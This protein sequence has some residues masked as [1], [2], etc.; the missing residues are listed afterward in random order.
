MAHRPRRRIGEHYCVHCHIQ[1][2][3][4]SDIDASM[5]LNCQWGEREFLE[6]GSYA[7]E[8]A[9]MEEFYRAEAATCSACGEQRI[10]LPRGGE[11]CIND[12][13]AEPVWLKEKLFS[14]YT[15]E[16]L[17][18]F[19]DRVRGDRAELLRE[20][21][22]QG[23]K[24]YRQEQI[25]NMAVEAAQAEHRRAREERLTYEEGTRR[26]EELGRL[27][28]RPRKSLPP[29]PPDVPHFDWLGR[30]FHGGGGNEGRRGPGRF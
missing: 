2:S 21:M 3:V 14:I 20:R 29:L 26:N 8:T 13:W 9:A 15:H 16:E 22:L 6:T 28:R 10:S 17:Q 23:F 11:F 25:N 24:D 12:C 27:A 1:L 18:R 4:K 19:M 30:D 7:E 5:C